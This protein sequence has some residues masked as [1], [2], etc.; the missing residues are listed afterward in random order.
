MRDKLK[1]QF[2]LYI[3]KKV[4]K[5]LEY[6]IEQFNSKTDLKNEIIK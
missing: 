3:L 1:K 2:F 4:I 6:R 5:F